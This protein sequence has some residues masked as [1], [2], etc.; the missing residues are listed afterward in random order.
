MLLSLDIVREIIEQLRA[1]NQLSTLLA[2]SL[3]CTAISGDALD[4]LWMKMSSL[5]P[6]LKCLP[7]DAWAQDDGVQW[8]SVEY[9][10]DTRRSHSLSPEAGPTTL[11]RK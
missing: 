6:L 10:L 2:L 9:F 3:T 11:E 5:V 4:A 1:E 8:V 7:S